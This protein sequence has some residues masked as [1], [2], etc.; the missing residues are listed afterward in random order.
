MLRYFHLNDHF[1]SKYKTNAQY[2]IV[3][4]RIMLLVL[5]FTVP[6]LIMDSYD[7]YGQM[8]VKTIEAIGASGVYKTDVEAAKHEAIANGLVAV[9]DKAVA[10]I[11]PVEL[12]AQNFQVINK[13]IYND[14]DKYISDYKV[15]TEAFSDKSYRVL[16]QANVSVK[17]LK[18]SLTKSGVMQVRRITFR[19]VEIVVQGTRNLSSF[20]KFR[21]GLKEIPGVKTIQVSDMQ[22]DEAKLVVNFEGSTKEFTDALVLKKF[23]NFSIRIF[24][25]SEDKLKVELIP[26]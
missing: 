3:I 1:I 13:T 23:D 24:E 14:T 18:N 6:L 12:V 11:L 10:E 20:I 19:N 7:A 8:E 5:S 16:I 26:G 17:K 9:L 4:R 15:L 25:I 22:P 2:S 21:E